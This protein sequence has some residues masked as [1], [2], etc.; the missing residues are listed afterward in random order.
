MSCRS[1]QRSLGQHKADR[2][3]ES[4][5]SKEQSTASGRAHHSSRRTP[6]RSCSPPRSSCRKSPPPRRHHR[7]CRTWPCSQPPQGSLLARPGRRRWWLCHPARNCHAPPSRPELPCKHSV[8]RH[9]RARERRLQ[10]VVFTLHE[11]LHEMTPLPVRQKSPLPASNS[12]LHASR[13]RSAAV[14]AAVR[15]RGR[16]PY[17]TCG[18]TGSWPRRRSSWRR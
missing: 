15:R 5:S 1:I 7:H 14:A 17:R 16:R 10:A 18:C 2:C 9:S 3:E 6:Q 8:R 4:R 11:S 13:L 12:F